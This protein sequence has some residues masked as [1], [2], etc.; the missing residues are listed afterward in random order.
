MDKSIT[1]G[2]QDKLTIQIGKL[3]S[4]VIYE[5]TED[6]LE[7]LE[8]G[9]SDS[10]FLSFAIFALSVAISFLATLFTIDIGP[11][12]IFSTFLIITVLGFFCGVVL[13]TIWWKNRKPVK[14]LAKKIRERIKPKSLNIIMK[15]LITEDHV[16]EVISSS[17]NIS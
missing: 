11:G 3:D 15:S 14:S 8:K 10:I 9:G 5:I 6:E 12:K 1:S 17:D 13:L 7:K 2:D 16:E 4:L